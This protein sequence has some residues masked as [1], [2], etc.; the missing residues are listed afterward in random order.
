M[1]NI[2]IS[3][4]YTDLSSVRTDKITFEDLKNKLALI[5]VYVREKDV[6]LYETN[7]IKLLKKLGKISRRHN[8]QTAI[9]NFPLR[10]YV[11]EPKVPKFFVTDF[12]E[13]SLRY[14]IGHRAL[15]VYKNNSI[16]EKIGHCLANERKLGILLGYPTC[17]VEE[18]VERKVRVIEVF[19]DALVRKYRPKSREEIKQLLDRDAEVPI[20]LPDN[21]DK[22][23]RQFPF[24]FHTACKACLS[25]ESS[26]SSILNLKYEK[27]ALGVSK[28]FHDEILD[29]A[30]ALCTRAI[31]GI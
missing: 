7:N 1:T 22:T 26:A 16:R 27:L 29:A 15:W 21:V 2:S 28:H 11:R 24:V 23:W 20:E 13:Y 9:T 19:Y 6:F 10:P 17:C 31:Q 4:F 3:R 18:Y 25:M 12:L 8:L 30:S 5:A 14:R